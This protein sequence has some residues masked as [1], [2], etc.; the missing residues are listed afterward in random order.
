M[1]RDIIKFENNL[2]ENIEENQNIEELRQEFIKMMA[3]EFNNPLTSIYSGS[4]LAIKFYKD[5]PKEHKDLLPENFLEILEIIYNGSKEI[6]DKFNKY[7]S[8]NY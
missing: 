7:I 3:H 6:K 2:K 4:Q 1:L 8:E 5:V